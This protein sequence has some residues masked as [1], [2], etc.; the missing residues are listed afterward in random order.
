MNLSSVGIPSNTNGQDASVNQSYSLPRDI[1]S[2]FG[3][4]L[5]ELRQ[6]RNLT[7]LAMAEQFG[8]DRSFISDVECGRKS[9]SLPTLEVMAL[10]F[11]LSLSD[12]LR[13]I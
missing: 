4:R 10:G 3:R 13:G 7:Q 9:I 11:K 6:S 12:I 8:I 1:S 5:R 2:R